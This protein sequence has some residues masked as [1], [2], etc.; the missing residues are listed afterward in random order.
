MKVVTELENEHKVIA[1]EDNGKGMSAEHLLHITDAFYREKGQQP[2]GYF[3]K[4]SD[5][6]TR[7]ST[8]LGK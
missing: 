3:A 7:V 4:T 1:V 8:F 2:N 5:G 6:S